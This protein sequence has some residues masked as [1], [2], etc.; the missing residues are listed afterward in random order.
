M[1]LN[2]G[3]IIGSRQ[4]GQFA[5]NQAD[6]VL[7]AKGMA[8]ACP[9]EESSFISPN[10]EC[11]SNDSREFR[12]PENHRDCRATASVNEGLWPFSP[13]NGILNPTD[14]CRDSLAAIKVISFVFR[15]AMQNFQVL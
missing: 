3:Q 9:T 14:R 5:L 7:S 12:L 8:V 13:P 4:H 6:A 1:R 15:N 10:A 2:V 11:W